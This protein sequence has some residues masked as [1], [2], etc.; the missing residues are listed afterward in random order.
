[1]ARFAKARA[2]RVPGARV[3]SVGARSVAAVAIENAVEGCVR[4]TYGA[5]VLAWQAAHAGDDELRGAFARIARD[6]ARHASLAWALAAWLEPQLDA[7]SRARVARARSRAIA[8]LAREQRDPPPSLVREAG[9]PTASESRA[10]LG[11]M[12]RELELTTAARRRSPRSAAPS[13]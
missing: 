5:L 4:E 7:R 9:L 6:E 10:L 8:R 1:M 3:R 12:T 11:A 2:A 13:P